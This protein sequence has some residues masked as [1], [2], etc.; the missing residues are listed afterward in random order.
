MTDPPRVLIADDHPPTRAGVRMALERDG[1]IV[2]AEAADAAATVEAALAQ[3][4][5]ACLIDV[6]MPG[7]GIRAVAQ[8]R[9]RLPGTVS[10]MLSVSS[11]S[12]D[13]FDA[14][15]AG[16]VGYLLKD[17]DPRELP[18]AVRAAIAGEVPM[19]GILTARLVEG[20]LQR[21]E[22]PVL[23][24]DANE[25]VGLTA[26]EWDVMELLGLGLSTADIARRLCLSK[27]TVRRHVSD[28]MRKLEVTS[29]DEA[30]RLVTR[31]D[32][33]RLGRSGT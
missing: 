13:L 30:R 11:R 2:C 6:D 19:P 10:I 18:V 20:F 25:P 9:A 32:N 4:P 14:L 8:L 33:G 27:V 22:R 28:S 31:R 7:G 1:C 21:P 17:M 15:R 24:T 16:A 12:E 26:R 23:Q 3:R 5:D 29:R